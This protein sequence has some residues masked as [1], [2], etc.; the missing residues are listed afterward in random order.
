M[1]SSLDDYNDPLYD[2]IVAHI[3]EESG[4]E[5]IAYANFLALDCSLA[6]YPEL[7][8]TKNMWQ[9]QLQ[10]A[11][12]SPHAALGYIHTLERLAVEN[13]DTVAA[14]VVEHGNDCE[15]FLTLHGSVDKSHCDEGLNQIKLA[16][17]HHR[18]IA[19][20]M[21]LAAQQYKFMVGAAQ[22]DRQ[23]LVVSEPADLDR[24]YSKI[25]AMV[26]LAVASSQ[27]HSRPDSWL[28]DS[29]SSGDARALVKNDKVIG[30]VVISLY[31]GEPYGEC[32]VWRGGNRHWTEIRK[33]IVDQSK[34]ISDAEYG[35]GAYYSGN[36]LAAEFNSSQAGYEKINADQLPASLLAHLNEYLHEIQ[37]VRIRLSGN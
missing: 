16:A 29:I 26:G 22:E 25:S 5:K 24:Y 8:A 23:A 31:G 36:R 11:L 2:Y 32:A 14:V 4:H 9:N 28:R 18:E 27:L 35:Y 34:K 17:G 1:L 12:K 15:S 13:A 10:T 33:M 6:D 19:K 21:V 37:I 30:F 7:Q 20:N 3:K